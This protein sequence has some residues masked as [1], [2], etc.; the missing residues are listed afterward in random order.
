MDGLGFE[1][2]PLMASE[3]LRIFRFEIC[4]QRWE[5]SD[6]FSSPYILRTTLLMTSEKL[7]KIHLVYGHRCILGLVKRPTRDACLC[8][9][10]LQ[11]PPAPHFVFLITL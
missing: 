3:K 11:A 8:M 9:G 7:R 1:D 2:Y 5:I 6:K 10:D 4:C